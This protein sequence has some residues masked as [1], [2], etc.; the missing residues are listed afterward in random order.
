MSDFRRIVMEVT[1]GALA[2]SMLTV[3]AFLYTVNNDVHALNIRQ[4]EDDSLR[5]EWREARER[6]IAAD[7]K[8]QA[9]QNQLRHLQHGIDKI[10]E[11]LHD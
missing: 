4:N 1:A 10:H 9:I 6:G 11:R 8:L 5:S 7:A 2:T 3:A